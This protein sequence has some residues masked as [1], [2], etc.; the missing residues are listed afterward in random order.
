MQSLALLPNNF[1][2]IGHFN[3]S[4]KVDLGLS[5]S[6]GDAYLSIEI[7]LL[8]KVLSSVIAYSYSPPIHPS[9]YIDY[10]LVL[11]STMLLLFLQEAFRED[12]GGWAI[13]CTAVVHGAAAH[14]PDFLEYLGDSH[15]SMIIKHGI[16]GEYKPFEEMPAAFQ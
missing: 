9:L 11:I 6:P 13:Y 16:I 14:L 5:I 10:R 3:L 1:Q 12:E 15:N 4:L 8:E 7:Y 2:F